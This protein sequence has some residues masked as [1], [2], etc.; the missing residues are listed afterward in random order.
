MNY[1]TKW[2][3]QKNVR[4]LHD[5]TRWLIYNGDISWAMTIWWTATA[6]TG[7][8]THS[9]PEPPGKTHHPTRATP[10]IVPWWYKAWTRTGT[11]N[12]NLQLQFLARGRFW[13]RYW[14]AFRF[15]GAFA[16]GFAF[17]RTWFTYFRLASFIAV[18]LAKIFACP[19]TC[20]YTY[21]F[22]NF[23]AFYLGY[24]D[25]FYYFQVLFEAQVDF[26]CQFTSHFHL[27]ICNY[28]TKLAKQLL[29]ELFGTKLTSYPYNIF[30]LL[31]DNCH[32]A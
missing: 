29:F 4:W 16:F 19:L 20:F 27:D 24:I 8:T 30:L 2:V 28:F 12:C 9:S 17:L 23:C 3:S 7:S 14:V 13:W 1:H 5:A 31:V 26:F 22:A 21:F 15:A 11:T 18:P 25:A 6:V 10:V 32:N